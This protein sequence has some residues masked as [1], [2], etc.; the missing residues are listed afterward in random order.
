MRGTILGYD[1]LRAEGSISGEDG[2]RYRFAGAEWKSEGSQL[3]EGTPVDFDPADGIAK[4][5][6]L[7]PVV[8][9]TQRPAGTMRAET[10]SPIVA[11]IL[12][13]LFGGLGVHKFYLGYTGEGVA[14]LA[15]T[16]ISVLTT[17]ILIGIIP[18]MI[19]S[20]VVFVEAILY[21]T[22]NEEDFNRIYVEGRKPWF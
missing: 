6:Y 17:M 19:I 14:L 11:G 5:V 9:R 3:Q 10:K 15:A 18:L 12:A 7:D 2:N 1:N 13:L 16:V 8:L 4:E 20:V 22:Q 21:L